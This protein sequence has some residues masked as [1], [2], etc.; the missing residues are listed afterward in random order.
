[1]G[2]LQTRT[3]SRTGSHL[4]SR[5]PNS[6]A[7]SGRE[8]TEATK[9]NHP[10]KP[11]IPSQRTNMKPYAILYLLLAYTAANAVADNKPN[12]L[13][14]TVDD[15]NFDS[16][17]VF[18]SE[19]EDITPNIDA[20]ADA[21]MRFEYS[22]VQAPSCTPSR[23]VFQTGHFPHNSGV[24][25]FFSVAFPQ[26]TLPEA[27][28]KRGYFT[29]ILQKVDDSV[30]TNDKNRYWDFALDLP[31]DSGRTPSKYRE[32]FS[33]LLAQAAE[34]GKP[35]YASINIT[36]P[37]LPFFRGALT[38]EGF[39]RTPPSRIY[40]PT[41]VPIPPFLPQKNHFGQEIA[42][43][44]NTVRRADD[45]VGEVMDVLE[46]LGLREDT[47][48]FFVSDHGMSVPFSKSNLYPQSVLAAWIVSWPGFIES[49]RVD[50]THMISAIDFMPTVLDMTD[51]PAPGP[52]AG[53]S[54]LPI[55]K[56]KQLSGFDEVFVEHTEGPTAEPR[57]MRAIH[58]KEFAYIFNAWATG[59]YQSVMES[60]WYRSYATF[61]QLAKQD[62]DIQERFD[63]LNFRTVEELYDLRTDPY[64][65]NNLIDDPNY[66]AVADEL[67]AKLEQW[68]IETNDFALPGFL[69]RND[70]EK[71]RAFMK[72]INAISLSRTPHIEWKRPGNRD[73]K[74][75]LGK[76]YAPA[77]IFDLP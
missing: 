13:F 32:G 76:G 12:I 69:Y 38:Q 47:V 67:S 53:R 66:R 29:G 57:P 42:D 9:D 30:P 45:C 25:G 6:D 33:A 61:E 11:N 37:H 74:P 48:V 64:A 28:R 1:M 51:T 59:D 71:L 2:T 22:Y 36:D 18:G 20:L 77:N 60:R 62:P 70:R 5:E 55:L 65:V 26:D 8:L 24:I 34:S 7:S 43:Y 17:G 58:T 72:T 41:D 10:S 68:M 3:S 73:G 21:G 31:L 19:V 15:M 44:Y 16:I 14:L 50:S 63:F 46:S 40:G 56:G 23:N 54:I 39:D 35:F 4:E 52:L 75:A 27:L 49:G